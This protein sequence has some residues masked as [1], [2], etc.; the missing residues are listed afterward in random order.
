VFRHIQSTPDPLIKE[1][2]ITTNTFVDTQIDQAT[3]F[4]TYG[5]SDRIDVSVA[6]PFV[7]ANLAVVSN[8][9]IQ[10]IG[11]ANDPTIH[12]FLDSNGNPTN[13]KQFSSSGAASGL[14]DELVR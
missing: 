1:D 4:F 8:A 3:A 5:L 12:F 9:T 10:R 13:H 6:L 14:G 7:N 2:L 11:T